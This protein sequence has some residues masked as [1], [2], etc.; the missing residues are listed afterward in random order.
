[1][2]AEYGIDGVG[3]VHVDQRTALDLLRPLLAALT[4]LPTRHAVGRPFHRYCLYK[5]SWS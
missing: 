5:S 1:M 3:G 4:A 2:P